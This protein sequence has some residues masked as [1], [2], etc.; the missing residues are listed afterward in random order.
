MAG[1]F[2]NI[3]S[4]QGEEK[5]M[6]DALH[7]F[8]D[9]QGRFAADYLPG[10]TYCIC[11]DNVRFASNIID[12]IPYEPATGK[13]N[14]PSLNVSPGRPVEIAVT[15]GP[16][17]SPV[18]HQVVT[19]RTHHD[20]TWSEDGQTQHGIG[21]RAWR[22]ATD[23]HGKAL[24]FAMPGSVLE[25]SIYTSGWQSTESVEVKRDGGARLKFHRKVAAKRKIA[26]RLLAPDKVD[27]DLK[28]AV[29]QISSQDGETR[30]HLTLT[31]GP[32][33][34]FGF[35]SQ[36]SR[37]GIYARTKDSKSAA[38]ALVDRL[39]QPI[40]MRLKPTAE[41]RGQLLGKEDAPL[42]GRTVRAS[43]AIAEKVNYSAPGIVFPANSYAAT[44]ESKT[45]DEG[46]YTLRGLPYEAPMTLVAD[47]IDG[48]GPGDYLGKF[49]LVPNESRPPHVSRL[50][51]KPQAT[52][53]FASRYARILR[54]CR[55]SHF[56]AMVI[57]FRPS[58]EAKK[59]VNAN[60]LEYEKTKEVA[61]YMQIQGQ[62]GDDPASAEIAEFGKSKGWPMPEKGRVF[63][64]AIDPTGKELARADFDPKDPQAQSWPHSSFVSMPPS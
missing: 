3:N 24:A 7:A 58:A 59:F 28:E 52:P 42:R 32:D 34:K 31:A 49:Y 25:G 26:G 35:E 60:L 41:Y 13:T 20:F 39:D 37:I 12:L 62:I 29:V 38:I 22:V 11:V 5:Y 16:A 43:L 55:L 56:Y 17:K 23:E 15:A 46:K 47:S 63:A 53:S 48:S 27:A 18:A 45:N 57:L 64:F 50:W 61:R 54:D 4:F 21:G 40:E 19:L 14:A 10:A 44:F 30:E 33:G 2:V 51:S 8:T 36:A 9:E 6:G 1:L